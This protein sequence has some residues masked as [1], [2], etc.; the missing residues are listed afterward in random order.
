MGE[1]LRRTVSAVMK[2]ST[3]ITSGS[4]QFGNDWMRHKQLVRRNRQSSLRGFGSSELTVHDLLFLIQYRQ[5]R[6]RFFLVT[7]PFIGLF[8]I[9]VVGYLAIPA[10]LYMPEKVLTG[11]LLTEEQRRSQQMALHTRRRAHF[12][13]ALL[14]LMET[15]TEKQAL[16]LQNIYVEQNVVDPTMTIEKT[17][18]LFKDASLALNKLHRHNLVELVLSFGGSRVAVVLPRPI[19]RSIL[20]KKASS[21]MGLLQALAQD[22]FE[23]HS[24]NISTLHSEALFELLFGE[25]VDNQQVEVA[26]TRLRRFSSLLNK[27]QEQNP[28]SQELQHSIFLHGLIFLASRN[29]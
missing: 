18:P 20:S 28:S 16:Q 5:C 27:L 23:F 19:L 7:F 9:P 10:F 22:N 13:K 4:K 25:C 2:I 1:L 24:S 8:C 29:L 12:R 15:M 17:I 11:P 21:L 6:R 14:E 26:L 3:Q